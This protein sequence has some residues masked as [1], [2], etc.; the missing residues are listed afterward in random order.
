MKLLISLLILGF[1]ALSA[2][3]TE[4]SGPRERDYSVMTADP[5]RSEVNL[6]QRRLTKFLVRLN[7]Q[8]RARLD[9][10][11]LVAVQAYELSAGEVP[12]L[13]SRIAKGSVRSNQFGQDISSGAQVRVKFLLIF[14]SRTQQLARPDG[15][16]VTDT[17]R[18]NA[19]GLFNGT[20][21]IYAGTGW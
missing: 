16:L 7:P 21:A 20:H 5:H 12:G 14:D 19:V 10:T 9:Q 4:P 8:E 3:A 11:P 18:L 17:P 13:T 2:S 6:A 1:F 15:V